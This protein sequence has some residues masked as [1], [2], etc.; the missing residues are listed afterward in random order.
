MVPHISKRVRLL[1]PS[2]RMADNFESNQKR[3]V[4]AKSL[5]KR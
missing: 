4:K 3:D 5:V 2:L 1:L